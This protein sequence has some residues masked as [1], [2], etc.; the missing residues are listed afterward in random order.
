M[1]AER[2]SRI[3][4]LEAALTAMTLF[5]DEATAAKAAMQARVQRLEDRVRSHAADALALRR[6]LERRRARKVEF[7][8]DRRPIRR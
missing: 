7:G 8:P 4:E 2:H 5:R 3:V 6:L 1:L